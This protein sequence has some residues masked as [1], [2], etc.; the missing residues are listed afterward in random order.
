MGFTVEIRFGYKSRWRS[1]LRL[2]LSFNCLSLFSCLG[3]NFGGS[4]CGEG[5]SH[6]L[7][8]LGLG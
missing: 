3:L 4:Q 6:G 8:Q 5:W 1:S 2:G 7:N